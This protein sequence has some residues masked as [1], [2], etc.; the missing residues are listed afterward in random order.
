MKDDRVG[1]HMHRAKISDGLYVEF[2]SPQLELGASLMMTCDWD[3]R[4]PKTLTHEQNKNYTKAR[5]EFIQKMV[6]ES[7]VE[8]AMG[9]TL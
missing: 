6:D 7:G 4:M 9:D 5:D 8:V 1:V 2:C 3:P